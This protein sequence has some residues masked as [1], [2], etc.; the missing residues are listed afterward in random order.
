MNNKIQ[1]LRCYTHDTEN[2]VNGEDGKKHR[3]VILFI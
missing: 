1:L 2:N 3:L